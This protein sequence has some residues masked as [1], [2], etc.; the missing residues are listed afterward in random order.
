METKKPPERE[1][2]RLTIRLPAELDKLLREEAERRGTNINQTML[3]ILIQ[4]FH[5]EYPHNL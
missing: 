4:Q 3:S 5:R 2:K 1:Q